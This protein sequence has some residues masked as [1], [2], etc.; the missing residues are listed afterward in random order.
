MEQ[1]NSFYNELQHLLCA[2]LERETEAKV[3]K[4]A[5]C[6]QGHINRLKNKKVSFG[7]LKLSTFLALFPHLAKH[8]A[9][10]VH[11][12]AEAIDAGIPPA[13]ANGSNSPNV[14]QAAGGSSVVVNA[15]GALVTYRM[16]LL[17]AV[18]EL[19]IETGAKDTV[20]RA[21]RAVPME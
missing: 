6:T 4:T 11:N 8:L 14:I 2:K 16:R 19:D 20:L 10:E 13:N 5:G 18:I 7:A 21:I 3:A 17:D 15:P 12:L 9:A 1:N